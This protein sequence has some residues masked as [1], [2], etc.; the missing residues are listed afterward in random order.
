MIAIG[1][2]GVTDATDMAVVA[3]CWMVVDDCVTAVV[4]FDKVLSISA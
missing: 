1:I 3:V 2:E 4:K